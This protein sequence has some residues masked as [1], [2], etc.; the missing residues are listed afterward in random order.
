MSEELKDK[1]NL[2]TYIKELLSR[3]PLDEKLLKNKKYLV[4]FGIIFII[5]WQSIYYFG[6][7]HISEEY[8]RDGITAFNHSLAQ[9]FVYF[10]Y[11]LD[12]FPLATTDTTLDYSVEGAKK[13]I[14]EKPQTL[15]TEWGHWT[16]LGRY[17]GIWLYMPYALFTGSPKNLEIIFTN[18][19]LFTLT[20]VL[21]YLM[22]WFIKKPFLGILMILILGNAPFMIYEIY[23]NNNIFGLM[24]VYALML[25]IIH[26]GYIFKYFN[27]YYIFMPLLSGILFGI[28]NHIRVEALGMIVSCIFLYLFYFRIKVLQR[29]F[30]VTT[31]MIVYFTT[32][33]IIKG[34]FDRKIKETEQ[35]VLQNGG[36]PFFASK[37]TMSY[38][39]IWHI[40]F[41]GLADHDNRYGLKWH[42]TMVFNR[43]LPILRK[44]TGRPLKYPGRTIYE[45]G[46]YYDSLGLYYIYPPEIPGYDSVARKL[47]IDYITRDPLWYIEILT[48]RVYDYFMKLPPLGISV[49]SKVIEIP[50]SGFFVLLLIGILLYLREYK[51]LIFVGFTMPLSIS[52]ILIYSGYT[53]YYQSAYHYF[54][55]ALLFYIMSGVFYK[56]K[57]TKNILDL[58]RKKFLFIF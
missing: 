58:L 11:Y 30:L 19:L 31:L 10:Y 26:I 20:L 22:F 5:I 37:G 2:F 53:T 44:V 55:A 45:M 33:S 43:V 50:F 6:K 27:R 57:N 12:L 38:S 29:V 52:V 40:L 16:R 8:R 1:R 32:S 54:A 39:A 18:Y 7:I 15:R 48:K 49:W 9:K 36:V 21:L 24:V 51:W 17:A 3:H 4:V 28:M 25:F 34:Y 14:Q 46:E 47:F 56:Y 42:D 13:I 23:C 41:C 35:I